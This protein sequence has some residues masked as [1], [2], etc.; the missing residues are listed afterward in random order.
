MH[1]QACQGLLSRIV[2][3]R[4]LYSSPL[5]KS[6]VP[7]AGDTNRN[8]CIEKSLLRTFEMSSHINSRDLPKPVG[9]TATNI[10]LPFRKYSKHFT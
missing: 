5:I 6:S 10:S 1:V 4:T 8:S 3:L 9:R 7:R 2:V